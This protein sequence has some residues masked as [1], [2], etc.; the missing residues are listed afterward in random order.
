MAAEPT[1]RETKVFRYSWKQALQVLALAGILLIGLIFTSGYSDVGVAV[2]L[3]IAA[4][5]ASYFAWLAMRVKLIVSPEGVTYVERG[6]KTHVAWENIH[7]VSNAPVAGRTDSRQFRLLSHGNVVLSFED[8]IRGSERAYRMIERR[9]SVELYPRYREALDRGEV[10]QFGV[11]NLSKYALQLR[12][13]NIATNEARLIREGHSLTVLRRGT[14]EV[15]IT[16]E[17]SDVPNINILMRA[18]SEID[19]HLVGTPRSGRAA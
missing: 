13:V 16:V 14:G 4:L 10:V 8:E 17:E 9:I 19:A 11:V 2:V 12:Q 7:A 3:G 18:A 1:T 5:P 6:N 15:V